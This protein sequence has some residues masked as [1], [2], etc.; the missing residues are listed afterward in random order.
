LPEY[1]VY[2]WV[3]GF[4]VYAGPGGRL[5]KGGVNV[6]KGLYASAM[7]MAV[8]QARQE[9]SANNL[10]NI[11]TAGY[12][13]D[14]IIARSFPDMLVYRLND[15]VADRDKPP[16][17]GK[18]SLGVRLD[19]AVTDYGPG[20]YEQTGDQCQLAIKGEGYFVVNTPAGERYTRCGEFNLTPE[21]VLTTT[22]GYP[23]MGQNGEIVITGG[24][25]AVSGQGDVLCD[26]KL[27]DRLRIVSA[28]GMVKEG[29][30][31]FRGEDPQ[32]VEAEVLQGFLEGS[33]ADPIAEMINM[34]EVMR[35]Y[36]TNMKV[37]QTHDAALEKAVNEIARV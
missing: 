29:S 22:D 28:S 36:E 1:R 27:I 6:L 30:S 21:G 35:A 13:K 33:N 8:L 11:V 26:G 3:M 4:N 14:Q 2:E 37:I 31:L 19:E 17:V 7:G 9:V 34:I 5:K 24:Q 12:K 10:A 23:V 20:K 25:F 32:E 18:I 15:P 16:Y